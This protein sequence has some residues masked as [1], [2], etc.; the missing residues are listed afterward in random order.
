MRARKPGYVDQWWRRS[1]LFGFAQVF[2]ANPGTTGLSM[3]LNLAAGSGTIRGQI[4]GPD[5]APVQGRVT[6]RIAPSAVDL[7]STYHTH[8]DGVFVLPA[9]PARTYSSRSS[10]PGFPSRSKRPSVAPPRSP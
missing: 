4:L 8:P 2:T 10:A 1:A 5:G 9:L 3:P 6:V 7:V